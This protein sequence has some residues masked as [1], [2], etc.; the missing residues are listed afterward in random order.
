LSFT[1][2]FKRVI[3]FTSYSDVQKQHHPQLTERQTELEEKKD[4]YW[5]P[6]LEVTGLTYLL[7]LRNSITI[8][9]MNYKPKI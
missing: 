7:E 8:N 6:F 5:K 1:L 2:N 9:P 3:Y 4:A